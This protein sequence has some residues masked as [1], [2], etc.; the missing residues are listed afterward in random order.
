MINLSRSI[1]LLI[2]MRMIILVL[3]SIRIELIIKILLLFLKNI[4]R[5]K[6]LDAWYVYLGNHS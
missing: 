6:D 1:I 2:C 5:R 3:S 4:V